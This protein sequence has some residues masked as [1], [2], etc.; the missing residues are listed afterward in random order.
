M[1]DAIENRSIYDLNRRHFYQSIVLHVGQRKYDRE[2]LGV[3]GGEGFGKVHNSVM[4]RL[5]EEV[6]KTWT[7]AGTHCPIAVGSWLIRGRDAV[8]G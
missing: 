8:Q 2:R 7:F 1:G 5:E 3:V 6:C 4:S